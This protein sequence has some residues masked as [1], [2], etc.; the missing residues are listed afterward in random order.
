MIAPICALLS[1]HLLSTLIPVSGFVIPSIP[2]RA[3]G[4]ATRAA[5][6]FPTTGATLGGRGV[7]AVEV[8]R[9]EAGQGEATAVIEP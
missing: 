5:E 1:A 2:L 6:G 8:G 4:K 9:V 7:Q 3:G